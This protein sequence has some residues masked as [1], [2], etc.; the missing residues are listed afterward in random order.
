MGSLEIE[1]Y[2]SAHGLFSWSALT[3]YSALSHRSFPFLSVLRCFS[4]ASWRLLPKASSSPQSENCAEHALV[5]WFNLGCFHI[6]ISS[7]EG[8]V[9]KVSR[10]RVRLTFVLWRV[11]MVEVSTCPW[12]IAPYANIRYL[13]LYASESFQALAQSWGVLLLSFL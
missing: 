8:R 13:W 2:H 12:E 7:G 3:S 4:L 6:M 1:L 10:Q 5:F 11:E 9:W